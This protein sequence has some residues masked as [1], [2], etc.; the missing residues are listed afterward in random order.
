MGRYRDCKSSNIDQGGK[1][2]QA[3]GRDFG[4]FAQ[5]R[6]QKIILNRH[7]VLLLGGA[8]IKQNRQTREIEREGGSS[9]GAGRNSIFRIR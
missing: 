3:R 8:L 7:P 1:L 6:H 4:G 5:L 9:I 2:E